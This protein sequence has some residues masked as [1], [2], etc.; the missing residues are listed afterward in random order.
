MVAD[1]R[2]IRVFISSTFRDMQLE[3]DELVK[4]VF[5]QIRRLCEQ[6]GVSWSEVDL[7]WGV[8][9]EQKAE[10]AVLPICLAEIDRTRPYF[11]GLLGQRYGWVPDE[12]PGP[13]VDQLGWLTDDA[14]RSVTEMEILHGVL[15]NPEAAGFAYF[16]LRDP[17]WVEGL[18]VD[19][20]AVFL[21]DSP[22]GVER[23]AELRQRIAA[24]GHPTVE[25]ADPVSLGERV[26]ADLTQLVERLY[27]EASVPDA[28]ARADA[29][30]AAFG[31]ARF[32]L[33]VERPALA[34]ELDAQAAGDGPPLLVTGESGVGASALVTRWADAWAGA[35]P[36]ETMVV[37]HV[38]ADAEAADHRAMAA[39]V[40]RA[41]TGDE[42]GDALA[43]ADPPAVRSALRQTFSA[44]E[45]RTLVVIDGVD[46]LD[47][48]DRAPDLRW[49]PAEVPANVRIVLTA[50]G[51]RPL[52]TFQ[53]R[54]W[55]TLAV[56]ALS[57][58]ERRQI[59]AEVLAAGAKGLDRENMD[60]VVAS[61]R[62]GNARFLRTVMD[63][64]RQ[65]GDHFTLRPLIDRLVA[66]ET[67][68]DL[69]EMVLGRYEADF[70]R[71]RPGLIGDV[72]TAL[73]AARRGLSESELLELLAEPGQD[74][75]PQAVWAPLHLAAEHG[76][77]SRAGLLGFAHPDLRRAVEDRFLPDDAGRRAAHARLAAY[78]AR[79]PL[80]GRV[81][82]EL[83]WQQA[84][85]GDL[86]GLRATL[87]DLAHLELAYTRNQPDVRRL[88]VR[89]AGTG[90]ELGEAMIAAYQPVLT[91]PAAYDQPLAE[92][93]L[94]DQSGQVLAAPAVDE[95]PLADPS[96]Q[97]R[98]DPSV[99]GRPLVDPPGQ[100]LANPSEQARAD[101]APGAT[102][103]ASD[104]GA[105]SSVVGSAA[106]TDRGP[107]AVG[108]APG[109]L[110]HVDPGR[111]G[112]GTRPAAR[113]APRQL[114]WGI[115]RL[116]SDAA[117]P[118]AALPLHR[119][120]VETARLDPAGSNDVPGGDARLRGALV[121]LGAAELSQGEL[122]RAEATLAEAV[123][124]C[125]SAGDERMLTYALGNLAMARRDLGRRDE[126]SELFAEEEQLCRRHDDE[127]GLQASLGNHA[128][129][130]RELG[131]Y[132]E[133]MALLREQEGVCRDLADPA[134]V[135]RSLAGQATVLADRG[136]LAA[137][138]ALTEQ[139]V[140]ITRSEGDV[141][142][143]AEALLNLA[144]HKVELGDSAG[145]VAA[146]DEAE[147]I[148]RR[149]ADPGLLARILLARGSQLG[150]VGQWA[151][152]ERVA[153]EAELT[154][155]QA[156][157][158]RLVAGALNI[159]GTAR[160]EQGDLP[161]AR[162]A[163]TAELEA[164]TSSHDESAAATAQ[165]NLG[166]VAVAEQRFDEA[167]QW[168]APAEQTFRRLDV[169]SQLLPLLA[170]RG[171]VHQMHGR[172]AEAVADLT[173]A[174]D[175]A[176]RMNAHAAVR[177]WAEPA[178]GL[179]YQIGDVARAE[180]LWGL[181]ATSARAT[182]DDAM[183]QKALGDGALLLINRAQPTGVA[184]DATNV[185]HAL[186]GRAAAMLDEQEQVCRRTG[187]AVGLAA[188]VGNRAIVL[189]YQGDLEGSLRCL[190]EQLTVATQ[191]GNAQGALF[192]T[193]NRGEVLG[194]LGRVPEAMQALNQARAT[195]AQYGLAPMVQQLD[196][197]IAALQHRN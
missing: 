36:G 171:Q 163:H 172:N 169:P 195:A 67:V 65:H 2:A 84:D 77:V 52:A 121:N 139:H 83:G 184:G 168:Y 166:N 51:A 54:G 11:I 87:S 179:A 117:A 62:T 102:P 153:R 187:D 72:F 21:E 152:A 151:E 94:A 26:L 175:A 183:L 22:I 4:R 75:L 23:L 18:P 135:A 194:L 33:F 98:A 101:T 78:F 70:E 40:V 68:D 164:A 19:E 56:P 131:R 125:R 154:A 47:D 144:V 148:A 91:D 157:L 58:T 97:V 37:H 1:D 49:L 93:P 85:A 27:P 28:A 109:H 145:A 110:P 44:V 146:A 42:S 17:A 113:R 59:A 122:A 16:Y 180:T 191:S 193:A 45:G 9:D 134:A 120:L 5:P 138:V 43:A 76:L 107:A 185:D 32:G 20:R 128:Q 8:T 156:N 173:D 86:D 41:L 60:A 80:S 177:Q 73:W 186:L 119:Y 123:D 181:L 143:L 188:C 100:P 159:V 133:A 35:H 111:P 63:E 178:L 165:T 106:P 167:L 115:A 55:P 197:M 103:A 71:D 118:G 38:D 155:R 15:N 127:F 12:I 176:A 130:L 136:D 82:D 112:A 150:G 162:A 158:P 31:Q 116:L 196:G 182:G 57:D 105:P 14:G 95:Q 170:N 124:R 25:Y 7:R 149:F 161:G 24:S 137:A 88:W 114:V 129:L 192:A 74:R 79:Q 61:P 90:P 174:A 10:G 189:R 104:H 126:A 142:G 66:A 64:L 141:R 147:E 89:L 160:R 29:V 13:L 190:D 96:G 140:E 132:D 46:R 6:R 39:R 69:L 48:V 81:T 50:S 30:H 108:I 92:Q 53:H 3:R 34:A 99:D